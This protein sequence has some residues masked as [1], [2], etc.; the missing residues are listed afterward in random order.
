MYSLVKHYREN[1]KLSK[2]YKNIFCSVICFSIITSILISF[3][4]LN[5]ILKFIFF[6]IYPLILT[7][8]FTFENLGIKWKFFYDIKNTH[9]CLDLYTDILHYKDREELVEFLKENNK[10][11]KSTVKY[12][13]DQSD[14]L[15]NKQKFKLS[16]LNIISLI[17]PISL[18]IYNNSN[19]KSNITFIIILIIISIIIINFI[20][21]ILDFCKIMTGREEL[22]DNLS[23]NLFEIYNDIN[24]IQQ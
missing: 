11:N 1:S 17:V 21:N 9:Y 7:Y 12:L 23:D 14:F 8:V 20:N 6:F 22:F 19:L 15:K 18:T 4:K 3:C 13:L 16:Y 2:F 5:L 24:N 10:F